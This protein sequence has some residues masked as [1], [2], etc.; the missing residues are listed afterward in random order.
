[1]KILAIY[2]GG[3]ATVAMVGMVW[4]E[5]FGVSGLR[6]SGRFFMTIKA[7]CALALGYGGCVVSFLLCAVHFKYLLGFKDCSK[8]YPERFFLRPGLLYYDYSEKERMY[9]KRGMVFGTAG[10]VLIFSVNWIE[11]FLGCN[12]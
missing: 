2:F 8:K 7:F 1:M 11:R 4:H 9:F 12:L 10:M 6:F 5:L 3:L